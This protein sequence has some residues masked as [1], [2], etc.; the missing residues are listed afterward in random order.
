ML[1]VA[2]E[3]VPTGGGQLMVATS[4][5]AV[6]VALTALA[7]TWLNPS[8]YLDTVFLLGTVANAHGDARWVFALGAMT[9]SVIWFFA[10]A[11]GAR[12]LAGWLATAR[13]WRIFDACIAALMV[14][15]AVGL[16]FAH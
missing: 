8:V 4:T 7:L 9:A 1:Q 14:V 11:L 5:R 3:P 2:E 15:L 6:R 16:V 13:A 10:V 12:L